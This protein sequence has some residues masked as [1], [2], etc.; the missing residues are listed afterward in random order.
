MLETLSSLLSY[1]VSSGSN[2][3]NLRDPCAVPSGV[4]LFYFI[5]TGRALSFK[6]ALT[7]GALLKREKSN[8]K[9]KNLNQ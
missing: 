5:A 6:R 4:F 2:T 9:K 7:Q 3:D 8:K 1:D